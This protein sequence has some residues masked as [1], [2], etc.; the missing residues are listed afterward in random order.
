MAAVKVAKLMDKGRVLLLAGLVG[1][2]QQLKAHWN[3]FALLFEGRAFRQTE[4]VTGIRWLDLTGVLGSAH[5]G[6]NRIECEHRKT[7]AICVWSIFH[8]FWIFPLCRPPS[9]FFL[10]KTRSTVQKKTPLNG[11]A[12]VSQR[13]KLYKSDG[14]YKNRRTAQDFSQA[15]S[16]RRSQPTDGTYSDKG[17]SQGEFDTVKLL[18]VLK[19]PIH[20]KSGHIFRVHPFPGRRTEQDDFLPEHLAMGNTY[21]VLYTYFLDKEP[22][23]EH[24][25]IGLTRCGVFE[26]TPAIRGQL[27]DGA[28]SAQR[29]N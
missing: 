5:F 18:E 28:G 13:R 14:L 16:C 4:H 11:G 12:L 8:I 26:D 9:P 3:G 29:A 22:K 17:Y 15:A 25:L 10:Y 21:Y 6:I 23:G 27:L 2:E 24:D 1:I 20:W 19:S 7:S